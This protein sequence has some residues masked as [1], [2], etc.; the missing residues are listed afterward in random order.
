MGNKIEN[1]KMFKQDQKNDQLIEELVNS[2]GILKDC[3]LA[4]EESSLEMH[5]FL[6][7]FTMKAGFGDD[8]EFLIYL[9]KIDI[10]RQKLNTRVI[11]AEGKN[12]QKIID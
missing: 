11:E 9:N 12:P 8:R 10:E 1:Q 4:L 7:D 3:F 2:V 5:S 6:T